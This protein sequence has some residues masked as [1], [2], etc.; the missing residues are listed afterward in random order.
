MSHLF[1][2]PTEGSEC[3]IN[4]HAL[5]AAILLTSALL[6]CQ[7]HSKQGLAWVVYS[8]KNVIII[9]ASFRILMSFW[10]WKMIIGCASILF[11][12][13]E[14][15]QNFGAVSSYINNLLNTALDWYAVNETGICKTRMLL[16]G[17]SITDLRTC[18]WKLKGLTRTVCCFV[19]ARGSWKDCTCTCAIFPRPSCID[20]ILRWHRKSWGNEDMLTAVMR[21]WGP[22]D[23]WPAASSR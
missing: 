9:F 18:D 8:R 20:V 22:R 16:G 14:A 10:R 1:W 19:D 12:R 15:C 11:A 21:E 6:G 2:K 23:R 7:H 5:G 17:F 4:T 3:E 13:F